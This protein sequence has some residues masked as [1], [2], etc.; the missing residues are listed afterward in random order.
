MPLSHP[1][2]LTTALSILLQHTP[3][4]TSAYLNKALLPTAL[5]HLPLG[6][7]S[8]LCGPGY[9]QSEFPVSWMLGARC[10]RSHAAGSPGT[11]TLCS[12][13][14]QG[15][16]HESVRALMPQSRGW[17]K[18]GIS[19]E[20]TQYNHVF[21][22]MA[23]VSAH[24]GIYFLRA[25]PPSQLQVLSGPSACDLGQRSFCIALWLPF[26]SLSSSFHPTFAI[27]HLWSE[28]TNYPPKSCSTFS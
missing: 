1:R 24:E 4:K 20:H 10:F 23:S 13:N 22:I 9:R 2:C 19:G 14:L 27:S 15:V 28:V 16:A 25:F 5:P 11:R 3:P 18:G 26:H 21:G 17:A 6:A 7:G 8:L 12:Q